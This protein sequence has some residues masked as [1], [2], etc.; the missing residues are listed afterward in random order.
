MLF[1]FIDNY[2]LIGS[3]YYLI[4]VLFSFLNEDDID[5]ILDTYFYFVCIYFWCPALLLIKKSD[6]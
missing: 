1:L 3:N 2:H 5:H 6:Y 4:F